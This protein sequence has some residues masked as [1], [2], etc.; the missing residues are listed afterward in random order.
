VDAAPEP[1]ARGAAHTAVL[2]ADRLLGGL[3]LG[4]RAAGIAVVML[5]AFR[6]AFILRYGKAVPAEASVLPALGM[7]ARFDLKI[8]CVAFLPAVLLEALA[9]WRALRVARSAWLALVYFA[10]ALTSFVNDGFYGFFQRRLDALVFGFFDDDTSAVWHSIWHE[11]PVVLGGLA[12]AAL[13]ALATRLA[14]GRRR[15]EGRPWAGSLRARVAMIAAAV[16]LLVL[17]IRGRAT[18]FPLNEQDL[19]V[20]AVPFV[21]AATPNGVFALWLAWQERQSLQIGTDARE[22]LRAWGFE[23]PAAAAAVLGLAPPDASDE[24]VATA[25]FRETPENRAAAARPPHVVVA[26][27]EGWGADLLRYHS[28][29]NDL[30]GRLAPHLARGIHFRRFLSAQGGTDPTLEA[31]LV[32]SPISPLTYSARGN[33]RYTQAAA[34]PFR[35][36]G[37]RTVFATGGSGSWR[38]I[39]RAMLNQGFDE[40]RD[41]EDVLAA[42][43]DAPRGIWGVFDGDLFRWAAARLREADARGERLFLVL[44]STSNHTPHVVPPGY[45]VGPLDLSVFEGRQLGDPALRR[46]ILETYQY[47][48]DALGGFLDEVRDAGLT[49]R[50]ILA[51]TGDHN[52]R[53]FFEYT[54]ASELPLRDGVPLFLAVPPAYLGGR[55]ADV[56]RWGSHRDIFPTLAG[57]ALSRA[58]VFRS[59]DDLLAPPTR[60]PRALARWDLT[61]SGTGASLRSAGQRLRW[62][63]GGLVP[64][65]DDACRTALDAISR[66][67]RAYVALLDW[68]VRR[69]VIGAGRT[70]AAPGAR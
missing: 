22:G 20:S 9:T 30:L 24:A 29:R 52:T 57:L 55:T 67:E 8:A 38:G 32:G 59:G 31:L 5:A 58:R 49:D 70:A 47:A 25:L 60:L 3:A 16:S 34:L 46:P 1:P 68:N 2:A 7:G 64:C 10:L 44:L 17:A 27:M 53:S 26:V 39:G 48:C 33:Q 40:I 62:D 61:I 50:T 43:P 54:N 6:L 35:A 14:L 36:A 23:T 65:A 66:E 18:G 42:Y 63:G 21:N 45:R 41:Q 69:Q 19:T 28:E 15:S 51:A 37:Y 11:H 13:A 56:E 4:F 12:A